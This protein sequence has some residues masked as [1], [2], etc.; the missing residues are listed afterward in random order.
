MVS[1]SLGVGILL[2]LASL[3]SAF[4][5]L[6]MNIQSLVFTISG[7]IMLGFFMKL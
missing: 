7:E 2:T 3:W 5:R 1:S 4:A 6:C